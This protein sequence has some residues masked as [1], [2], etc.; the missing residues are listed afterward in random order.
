MIKPSFVNIQRPLLTVMV[1]DGTLA[2]DK[3]IIANTLQG[4]AEAF[5]I[6]LELLKPEERTPEKLKELFASCEGRPIYIT[7]YRQGLTDEQCVELMLRGLEAGATM[8]DVMGDLY[9]PSP[10]QMT[11]DAETVA[12]QKALIETIHERGGEVIMSAHLPD[13][14]DAETVMAYARA[15]A[16]RGADVVKIVSLAHTEEQMMVNINL[17]HRLKRELDRPFLFLNNGK[18][19]KLLRQI[20]PAL[21]SCMYLCL[22]SYTDRRLGLQ[23]LLHAVKDIRD[24]MGL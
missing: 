7:A 8:C 24:A 11:F 20:G 22:E 2:A 9:Q 14:R 5:C 23:P 21:G 16:E 12:K 17:T 19:G 10:D 6:Q 15:Q 13:F 3:A 18:H 1:N 4:G